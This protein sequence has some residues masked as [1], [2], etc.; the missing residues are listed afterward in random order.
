MIERVAVYR[1]LNR[2]GVVWSVKSM[3]TGLVVD[4]VGFIMLDQGELKVSEKGRQR[5]LKEKRKNVH[6]T[7]R[8]FPMD[9]PSRWVTKD[10]GWVRVEYNP[11]KYS[12]FVYSSNKK[13][14]TKIKRIAL[15]QTGCYVLR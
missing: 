12:S 2:K 5:V 4:R 7:A 13:P 11:Y 14:V 10:R 15:T 3:K 9:Y 6:A 1:N 8:G